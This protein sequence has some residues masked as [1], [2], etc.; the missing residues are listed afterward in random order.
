MDQ[1]EKNARKSRSKAYCESL[2][3]T[4]R[5]AGA[6]FEAEHKHSV[7]TAQANLRWRIPMM[8]IPFN[9]ESIPTGL[10][11]LEIMTRM[12]ELRTN[13]EELNRIRAQSAEIV[14]TIKPTADDIL[15]ECDMECVTQWLQTQGRRDVAS[16]DHDKGLERST[17]EGVFS[18]NHISIF[19]LL[20]TLFCS[21]LRALLCLCTVTSSSHDSC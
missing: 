15:L 6:I 19:P 17:I 21:Y 14:A 4:N 13:S 12:S 10:T 1:T 20:H 11:D 7:L 5:L 18:A 2:E 9:P 8:V 3:K 16:I